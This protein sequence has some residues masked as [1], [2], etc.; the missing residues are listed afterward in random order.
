M[1][2]GD[3]AGANPAV[4]PG[5]YAPSTRPTTIVP[6]YEYA[7]RSTSTQPTL[8]LTSTVPSCGTIRA[9]VVAPLTVQFRGTLVSG[10]V[11]APAITTGKVSVPFA[12]TTEPLHEFPDWSKQTT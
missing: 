8:K 5:E 7:I 9:R 4:I 2:L 1:P 3:H 6:L 12:R 11:W 10:T